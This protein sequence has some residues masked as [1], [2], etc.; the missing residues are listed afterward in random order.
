MTPAHRAIAHVE[1][2]AEL[3]GT[4][5]RRRTHATLA[6]LEVATRAHPEARREWDAAVRL[7][8]A[9]ALESS[10][11]A[12][13]IARR[14]S[15]DAPDDL[16]QE[17]LIGIYEAAQTFDPDRGLRFR[18]H[19]QWWARARI[20]LAN[21]QRGQ[22]IRVPSNASETLRVADLVAR[23]LERRG[24]DA[25]HARV[26]AGLE[27]VNNMAPA[28]L[29]AMI[30]A[31]RGVVSASTPIGE[32][33]MLA[34]TL[35]AESWDPEADLDRRA[36]VQRVVEAVSALPRREAAVVRHRYWRE[37]GS[38]AI[39][40]VLGFSKETERKAHRSALARLRDEVVL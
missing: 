23:D 30:N 24:V 39:A 22:T 15:R 11:V 35:A 33:I 17:G 12:A 36:L 13:R 25:T 21:E 26:L 28:H 7:W 5:L 37:E 34:D 9:M 32:G 16:V 31:R 2:A 14:Y 8:W 40:K 29:A 10:G 19:A 18:T 4:P 1:R 20:H 38:T 3:D 6:A 27:G